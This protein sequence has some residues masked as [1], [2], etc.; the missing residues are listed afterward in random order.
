MAKKAAKKP[1]QK[2]Q[3]RDTVAELR[4]QK[5]AWFKLITGDEVM[6]Q[7]MREDRK[8]YMILDPMTVVYLGDSM[9]LT[10]YCLFSE[11]RDIHFQHASIAVVVPI[12]PLMKE[13]YRHSVHYSLERNKAMFDALVAQGLA[14]IKKIIAG[15]GKVKVAEEIGPT[16][17][18][19]QQIEEEGGAAQDDRTKKS[20]VDDLMK[21]AE[22]RGLTGKVKKEDNAGDKEE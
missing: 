16:D 3:K 11:T 10:P 21:L 9:M 15:E 18:E 2:A 7:V 22:E 20:L 19:L 12:D 4:Y 8:G 1:R 5:V 17:A 13:Y 14:S 6:A